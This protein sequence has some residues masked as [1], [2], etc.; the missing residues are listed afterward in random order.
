MRP[1]GRPH[2]QSLVALAG[3]PR[4]PQCLIAVQRKGPRTTNCSPRHQCCLKRRGQVASSGRAS[5]FL[6]W[7]SQFTSP[8]QFAACCGVAIPV[9]RHPVAKVGHRPGLDALATSC[10]GAV[11]H[12]VRLAM[13][14][15]I[16]R[17]ADV[18]WVRP[19][20][21]GGQGY[22]KRCGRILVDRENRERLAGDVGADR[23]IAPALAGGG[24]SGFHMRRCAVRVWTG[25]VR[26]LCWWRS[27]RCR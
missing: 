8:G 16:P 24:E 25:V 13:V 26:G 21:L 9:V 10:P 2:C 3:R 23:S 27:V 1:H 19:S 20:A 17:T 18:L 4:K 14:A 7:I 12:H 6:P 5:G 11:D 15:Q 22:V